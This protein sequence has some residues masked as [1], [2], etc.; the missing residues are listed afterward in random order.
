MTTKELDK[1]VNDAVTETLRS[2]ADGLQK[3]ISDEL[4]IRKNDDEGWAIVIS[5][6]M[7]AAA[8]YGALSAISVLKKLNVINL[9]E[10]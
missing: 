3:T 9:E 10:L 6:S 8:R 5:R 1:I 4:K 2:N 7:E